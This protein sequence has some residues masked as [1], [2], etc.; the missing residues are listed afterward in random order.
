MKIL[1]VCAGN[2]VM[3]YAMRKHV[4]ANVENRATFHSKHQEQWRA[5]FHD[6]PLY[7]E[8]QDDIQD[9]D[10]IIG[11]PDCGH[12]SILSYS[13]KKTLG[14]PKENASMDL[15]I[16]AI[17]THRPKGFVMENLPKLKDTLGDFNEVFPDYDLRVINGSVSM[18]GNSQVNRIRLLIIGVR[19]DL[20]SKEVLN[21]F[22]VLPE[23]TYK[24]KTTGEL[25]NDLSPW[26]EF[27]TGN[28]RE[29]DD[30]IITMYTGYKLS[31]YEIHSEWNNERAGESRWKVKDRNFTTA[32]GVYRNLEQKP[33]NTVRKGNRE[34]NPA[35]YMMSP[36]E[37]ALIQGLPYSFKIYIDKSNP[38]YWINK[39]RTTVTKCPPYHVS[40]WLNRQIKRVKRRGLLVKKN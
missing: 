1:G 22:K 33:P 28:I 3:I 35:G 25:F 38:G 19:K 15:Y 13:R 26:D 21:T 37:R 8:L 36:R 12:S 24:P 31:A 7:R 5:N 30:T 34:F 23:G 17:T 9:I 20:K 29:S 39:G 11:H 6:V 40:K 14:N 4:I 18:F 16:S 32:P 10:W 2:G 27:E